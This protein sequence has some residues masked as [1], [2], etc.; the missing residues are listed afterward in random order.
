MCVSVCERDSVCERA[1]RS[2]PDP[3]AADTHEV[4]LREKFGSNTRT[5]HW[6]EQHAEEETRRGFTRGAVLS[7]RLGVA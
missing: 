6:T 3:G 4:E 1:T 7:P 2:D 5:D